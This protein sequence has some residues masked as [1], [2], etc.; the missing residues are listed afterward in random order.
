MSCYITCVIYTKCPVMLYNMYC[1]MLCYKT[2]V[3]LYMLCYITCVMYMLCYITYVMSYNMYRVMLCYI[4][5]VM[6]HNIG[7]VIKCYVI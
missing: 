4:T 3:L 6:L 5:C 1:V 7:H 2:R